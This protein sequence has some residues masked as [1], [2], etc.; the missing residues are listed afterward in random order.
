[1]SILLQILLPFSVWAGLT[2]DSAL[3]KNAWEDERGV[4]WA[5]TYLEGEQTYSQAQEACQQLGRAR[6]P[7]G[8][9]L[10]F[11]LA[12]QDPEKPDY[13][14]NSQI[15]WKLKS[16]HGFKFSSRNSLE[17]TGLN[18]E[19]DQSKTLCVLDP[20]PQ[21]P[22][23]PQKSTTLKTATQVG[24]GGLLVYLT[25]RFSNIGDQSVPEWALGKIGSACELF[26]SFCKENPFLATYYTQILGDMNRRLIHSSKDQLDR[27]YQKMA[28]KWW[29][30]ETEVIANENTFW[31][32][33]K[34]PKEN[35]STDIEIDSNSAEDYRTFR[36]NSAGPVKVA[37]VQGARDH[38]AYQFFL[39][40]QN[41]Q[42][43]LITSTQQSYVKLVHQF[44][45]FCAELPVIKKLLRHFAYGD[46][47][48]PNSNFFA[49]LKTLP[50]TALIGTATVYCAKNLLSLKIT[51]NQIWNWC[52]SH[53]WVS[54]AAPFIYNNLSNLFGELGQ[55]TC[56]RITG[57]VWD[58]I[59][60]DH[61]WGL[62]SNFIAGENPVLKLISPDQK[63]SRDIF[64]TQESLDRYQCLIAKLPENDKMIQII[65]C[66]VDH[67]FILRGKNWN[68]ALMEC[69][70]P[71]EAEAQKAVEFFKQF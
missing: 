63:Q 40:A 48:A 33:L 46:P 31:L 47:S 27:L 5:S 62:G 22:A 50:P 65:K 8:K 17:L 49:L 24:A 60:S 7:R 26:N 67:Q 3:G 23:L 19:S 11:Y 35:Y 36:Q 44:Y 13:S 68:C 4:T 1:M 10:K 6:L 12:S 25:H 20:Q 14:V 18:P 53:P 56:Q 59:F 54:V 61:W 21:L 41:G 70:H 37:E 66:P 29:G 71:K 51:P 69:P 16:P 57:E 28:L 43:V 2:D 9:D 15:A 52:T 32:R 34:Y 39:E 64:I 58:L 55:K 45:R 30:L 38:Q 42:K